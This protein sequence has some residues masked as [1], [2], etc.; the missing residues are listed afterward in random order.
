MVD[1]EDPAPTRHDDRGELG[2]LVVGEPEGHAEAVAQRRGQQAGPRRRAD[3]RERRQVE[4]QRPCRR[5]LADDDVEAEVLERRVEDLLDRRVQPV[6]LVDE[7]HVARL[8]RR[9]DRSQVALALER[10]PGDR[11]DADAELLADDVREARLAEA[12]AGRRAGRGRA[13]RPRVI[14]AVSATSSCA[15]S[16][17]WPT[18]SASWRGRS[19]RSNSSSSPLERQARGSWVSVMRPS[20]SASRTRSSGAQL[21]IDAGEDALG[22]DDRPAELDERVA[23]DETPSDAGDGGE[24][25]R[26]ADLLL[27]L[28]HDPLRRLLAD[29][30][31]RLEPRRVLER[32][33]AAKL[34][35]A[36][37]PRR[38]RA[39]PSARRR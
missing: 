23:G 30:R 33:R 36:T 34:G 9:E 35:T 14:A 26:V 39:R 27:Q 28:Q 31:D 2:R 37:S 22:L 18:N 17:S 32:D 19:E 25:D 24:L 20:C 1:A 15:F 16:R 29:P 7:Q 4:R 10:R 3:E 8:E 5:P 11:A 38:S 6:D 13:P 12:R 21:R